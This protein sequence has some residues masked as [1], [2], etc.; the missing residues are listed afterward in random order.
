[1]RKP[2]LAV[3]A[4][5]ALAVGLSACVP[6]PE[7]GRFTDDALTT[8]T[9]TCRVA[10]D[11]A[12]PLTRMMQA[13]AAEGIQLRPETQAWF[14]SVVVNPPSDESCYRSY[15]M[16]V[17]WRDLYCSV[18]QCG[19]AAPPGTSIHGWGRAV[20]FEDEQGE[21]TFASPGFLW[22]ET[23]AGEYGFVHPDWASAWGT[24]PEPWHWEHP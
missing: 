3:V 23:H 8:V 20:D 2:V 11:V 9:P 5:A 12:G 21:L 22:L 1:V 10:N 14:G 13:A 6:P 7:N 15:D 18:G 24:S 16:Q 4:M 19:F 17:W